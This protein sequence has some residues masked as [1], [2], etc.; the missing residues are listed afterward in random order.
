LES[1]GTCS[2]MHEYG[3]HCPVP[4]RPEAEWNTWYDSICLDLKASKINHSKTEPQLP[5][6]ACGGGVMEVGSGEWGS[7]GGVQGGQG[8]GEGVRKGDWVGGMR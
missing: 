7:G 2:N 3:K 6:C 5:Q 1:T 8:R 4:E